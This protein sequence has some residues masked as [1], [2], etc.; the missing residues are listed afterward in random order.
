VL[1][2]YNFEKYENSWVELMDKV[3]NEMGSWNTRTGYKRW[4]IMEVA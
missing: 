2:N 4:H 3:V 1:K